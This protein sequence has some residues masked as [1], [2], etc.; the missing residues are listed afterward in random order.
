M[1]SL[2][3]FLTNHH[4]IKLSNAD[5]RPIPITNLFKQFL[6]CLNINVA[7]LCSMHRNRLKV[8]SQ[9]VFIIN[10][11]AICTIRLAQSNFHSIHAVQITSMCNSKDNLCNV[12]FCF[13]HF[14]KI[15]ST[16]LFIGSPTCFC[17]RRSLHTSFCAPQEKHQ[18]SPTLI[19]YPIKSCNQR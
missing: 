11:M 6:K 2:T 7:Y 13:S 8:V 5:C 1:V 16:P 3:M 10:S 12:S 9:L 15:T 19:F 17:G 4:P 14:I 18:F